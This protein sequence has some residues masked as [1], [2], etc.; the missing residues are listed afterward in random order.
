MRVLIADDNE[1]VR[2]AI[3][4]LVE[5]A[6]GLVVSGE[7]GDGAEAIAEVGR[8]PPDLVIMDIHMPGIDGLEATSRIV[9]NWPQVRVVVLT[10]DPTMVLEAIA[11]GAAGCL[12]KGDR[13]ESLVAA[14][15]EAAT[16]ALSGPDLRRI[17]QIGAA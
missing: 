2:K 6:G 16:R 3:R 9:V 13:P 4:G 14:L 12:I 10:A 11:A 8:N 5:G 7:A 1:D 17:Q 15:R